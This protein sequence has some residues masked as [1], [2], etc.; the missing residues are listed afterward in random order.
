M[1]HCVPQNAGCCS[2]RRPVDPEAVHL[3]CLDGVLFSWRRSKHGGIDQ[4]LADIAFELRPH[5]LHR[6]PMP[7]AVQASSSRMVPPASRMFWRLA[8]SLAAT[9]ALASVGHI[10][11]DGDKL[12]THI[13][14]QAVQPLGRGHQKVGQ[15]L[16][17]GFGHTVL[18]LEELLGVDVRPGVFLPVDNAGLQRAVDFLEGKLLGGSAHRFDHGHGNVRGLDAELQAVGIRR[19]QQRLVGRELLQAGGPVAEAG[20]ANLS[21]I[22]VSRPLPASDWVKLSTAIRGLQTGTAGR[23]GGT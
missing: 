23:T 4:V 12:V 1:P 15:K 6:R 19:H 17:V 9:E 22:T 10:V 2:R 14:H 8:A 3:F 20:V 5:R 21:S 13:R 11:D 16:V 18:H 7:C